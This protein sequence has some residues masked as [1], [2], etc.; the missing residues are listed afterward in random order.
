MNYG[1][2]S[3]I[4]VKWHCLAVYHWACCVCFFVFSIRNTRKELNDVL[5]AQKRT[6]EA[7]NLYK[8][9]CGKTP[10]EDKFTV[11]GIYKK[12]RAFLYATSEEVIKAYKTQQ[13][14]IR[15]MIMWYFWPVPFLF[16]G[17][18]I[19]FLKETDFTHPLFVVCA[20][21]FVGWAI[22][23]FIYMAKASKTIRIVKFGENIT[24]LNY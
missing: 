11:V 10:E 17:M 8:K 5:E 21:L 1:K 13:N 22:L 16:I 6:D 3:R 24:Y 4:F 9:K 7:I 2:F 20:I 19:G 15:R 14:I 23:G 18:L 12:Q